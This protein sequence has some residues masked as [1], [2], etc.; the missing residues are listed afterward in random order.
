VIPLKLLAQPS[1]VETKVDTK[2]VLRKL[3]AVSISV[4]CNGCA[5]QH[6]LVAVDNLVFQ[7]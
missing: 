1:W 7:N 6:G 5:P 3:T 2:E 4:Y